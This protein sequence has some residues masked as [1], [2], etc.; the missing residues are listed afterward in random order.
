MRA[1][2]KDRAALHKLVVDLR[3]I[4]LSAKPP[5]KPVTT[6][7]VEKPP[8]KAQ[9]TIQKR[10][11]P[12]QSAL[13][14]TVPLSQTPSKESDAPS[15]KSKQKKKKKKRSV[16]ANQGN[17]H[18]VDNCKCIAL[19]LLEPHL[20]FQLILDRPA[21]KALA[22]SDPYEPYPHHASLLFPPPMRLLATGPQR[23][24]APLPGSAPTSRPSRAAEDDFVCCF[25]EID[26]FFGSENARKRA[27]RRM[28]AE[29]RRK[30]NI[31]N[32]A[33]DV[34]EGKGT[35]KDDETDFEDDYS[36]GDDDGTGRCT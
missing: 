11:P 4:A 6:T 18:H 31:R 3:G 13:E 19:A 24:T 32:K 7:T 9:R 5:V 35:L 2:A 10:P 16:L 34:A 20:E 27:I 36:C 1:R 12:P 23:K 30:D 25:C 17:P 15:G 14:N 29:R 22:Q 8:Q 33:K 28:K 26:L 21:R